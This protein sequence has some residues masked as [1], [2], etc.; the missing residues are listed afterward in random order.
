MLFVY[1]CL[2]EWPIA[3]GCKPVPY[4]G[5]VVQIHLHAMFDASPYSFPFAILNQP[6]S[7]AFLAG[8]FIGRKIFFLIA[9]YLDIFYGIVKLCEGRNKKNNEEKKYEKISATEKILV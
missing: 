6:L 1:V 8:F 2:A 4:K 9:C 5:A 7:P 3:T